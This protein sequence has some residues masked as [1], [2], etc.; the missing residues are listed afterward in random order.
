[1]EPEND[2]LEDDFSFQL[3]WFLGQPLIFRGVFPS[4]R[5]AHPQAPGS[6]PMRH[7]K[8][9]R[10]RLAELPPQAQQRRVI[11]QAGH[12]GAAALNA[13]VLKPLKGWR[14]VNKRRCFLVCSC[15]GDIIIIKSYT[16]VH[17]RSVTSHISLWHLHSSIQY[18]LTSAFELSISGWTCNR[19]PQTC[20]FQKTSRTWRR[21]MGTSGVPQWSTKCISNAPGCQHNHFQFKQLKK[22]LILEYWN[23]FTIQIFPTS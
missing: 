4:S 20:F 6:I 16:V 1:M 8:S 9:P 12:I 14:R 3:G 22:M 5:F 15:T 18:Y 21:D 13:C 17:V 19:F 11:A 2:G 10:T 23:D 7:F